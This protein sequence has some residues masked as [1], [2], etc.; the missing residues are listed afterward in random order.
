[1]NNKLLTTLRAIN[2]PATILVG[3][4]LIHF[5]QKSFDASTLW[6]ETTTILAS[7][8]NLMVPTL[9]CALSY[10]I[11]CLLSY[12]RLMRLALFFSC[13]FFLSSH[14]NQ[15]EKI[16]NIDDTNTPSLKLNYL[17][18]KEKASFF[19][20]EKKNQLIFRFQEYYFEKG[21]RKKKKTEKIIKLKKDL[22]STQVKEILTKLRKVKDLR[23]RTHLL[24]SHDTL[25]KSLL[26]KINS[27]LIIPDE[28]GGQTC[29]TIAIRRGNSN[30]QAA[31]LLSGFGSSNLTNPSL[32]TSRKTKQKDP[33]Y[34][35]PCL[36]RQNNEPHLHFFT[37]RIK[38]A[39]Y[40]IRNSLNNLNH[41][42]SLDIFW[43]NLKAKTYLSWSYS[44]DFKLQEHYFFFVSPKIKDR[45]QGIINTLFFDKTHWKPK[46]P[47]LDRVNHNTYSL[48]ATPKAQ[49]SDY[50]P[51]KKMEEGCKYQIGKQLIERCIEKLSFDRGHDW[52]SQQECN[53]DL[54]DVIKNYYQREEKVKEINCHK[55]DLPNLNRAFIIADHFEEDLNAF[56]ELITLKKIKPTKHKSDL[57]AMDEFIKQFYKKRPLFLDDHEVISSAEANQVE[58]KELLLEYAWPFDRE[59]WTHSFPKLSTKLNTFLLYRTYTQYVRSH[60]D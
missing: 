28:L 3:A 44:N 9:I 50:F 47:E 25:T 7:N 20:D 10:F 13:G 48:S 52:P 31:D 2:Y 51:L 58:N 21:K 6:Q 46:F 15:I 8:N 59:D 57:V 39:Y 55:S 29:Q 30:S 12:S 54:F 38:Y 41:L 22:E 17:G 1:M 37:R 16:I 35:V 23:I 11:A 18:P 14:L 36:E 32:E 4:V 45:Y 42:K 56:T 27:N 34:K 33:T 60:E 40:R 43:Y 24:K 5:Y 53:Q 19:Y 26:K 49:L